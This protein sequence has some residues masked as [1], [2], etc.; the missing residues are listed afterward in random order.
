VSTRSRGDLGEG[1]ARGYLEQHGYE[2]IASNF[3]ARGGEID[4]VMKDGI[5]IVFIEVKL[6]TNAW[7]GAGAEAVGREK[8]RRLRL[9]C[10]YFLLRERVSA[11]WRIDV[12][13]VDLSRL[14]PAFEHLVSA[15][16]E[17]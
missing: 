8:R 1:L 13:V 14:E 7:F 12:V 4:L 17:E 5:E 10:R 9:A 2:F 3:Y 15:V 6:R 11:P 16:G